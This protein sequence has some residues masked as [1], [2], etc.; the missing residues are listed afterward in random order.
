M[1]QSFAEAKTTARSAERL[2]V[3]LDDVNGQANALLMVAGAILGD[4]DFAEAKDVAK[5]AR[6]HFR[7]IGNAKGEDGA[8]DFL[9][10]LK[11]YESGASDRNDFMGFTM[12]IINPQDNKPRKTEDGS[13]KKARDTTLLSNVE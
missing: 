1:N 5:E 3:E 11:S 9:Y 2:F 10:A 12:G 13:K 7:D 6:E 4:G 8:E